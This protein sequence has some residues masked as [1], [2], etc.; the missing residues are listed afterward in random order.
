MK[1]EIV[2]ILLKPDV[3]A[4]GLTEYIIDH[5]DRTGLELIAMKIV[6]VSKVLAEAH[7]RHLKGQPFFGEIVNYL[8]GNLHGRKKLSHLSMGG[9]KP[10]LFA[11]GSPA[12]PIRK[13]RT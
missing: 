13:M 3:Q 6:K 9:P 10:S 11:A 1:K 12:R 7:Y 8:Q 4:K 5:F 2:L